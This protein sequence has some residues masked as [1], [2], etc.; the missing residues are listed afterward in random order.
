[1]TI[2]GALA[3]FLSVALA[4][5]ASEGGVTGTGISASVSGGITSVGQPAD[6]AA[7]PFP[8]RI[9]V[10]QA[11]AVT[12]VAAADGTF[13]LRGRF[14]GAVTLLFS[15]AATDAPIGPLPLEIPAGSVTLLENIEIDPAAAP[16]ARVRPLAVR[17]LDVVG[18]VDLAECVGDGATVLV[19]DAARPPRQF[20][21]S[22]TADTEIQARDGTPLDCVALREG[23][24]IGVEGFLRLRTQSLVATRILVAPPR[25]S[26]PD[27][28][29]RERF[30]GLALAVDCARGEL[31]LAQHPD[32]ESITRRIQLSEATEVRCGTDPPRACGC[33]DIAVGSGIA[34]NGTIFPRRPG[35]VV[36]DVVTVTPAPRVT[37]L[38]SI[39]R[40]DCGRGELAVQDAAPGDRIVR[41]VLSPA[42]TIQC[43]RTACACAALGVRDRVRVEGALLGADPPVLA[44]TA[45]TVLAPTR[46]AGS[47]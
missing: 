7:L 23:L 19:S 16:A 36:A 22:V 39:G 32:G 28:P 1:M 17:Q 31:V 47:P 20:L 35:V 45:V 21:V 12:T 46:P 27:E 43:G 42:T 38:G 8:I 14:S 26:P 30:R 10:A 9:T 6:A 25:P 24:L 2:R 37:L 40:A 13:A 11:P 4:G 18:R 5:C 15:D 41:V 33:A 44:A 34:G 3:L 29:R